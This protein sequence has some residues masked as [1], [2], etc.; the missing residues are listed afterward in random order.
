MIIYSCSV[1]KAFLPIIPIGEK[2]RTFS[3]VGKDVAK[4][5]VVT[6]FWNLILIFNPLPCA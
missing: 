6:S 5:K 1:Q 4:Y 3:I 2:I